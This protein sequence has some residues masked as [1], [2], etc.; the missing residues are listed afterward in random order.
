MTVA[1]TMITEMSAAGRWVTGTD[2]G[3]D[4]LG[5]RL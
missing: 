2:P 5:H 4:L 1:A 3:A